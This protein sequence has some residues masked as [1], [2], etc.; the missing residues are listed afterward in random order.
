MDGW[1]RDAIDL[2]GPAIIEITADGCGSLRFVAVEGFIDARHVD[3]DG[4]PAVEFSWDGY[5]EGD[6][7]SGR[8]WARLDEDGSL[9][10]T[11]SSILVTSLAFAWSP[12]TCPNDGLYAL[13]AVVVS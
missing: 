6:Q 10:A 3:L 5:D 8:G 9:R 7:V 2:V 12:L 11:S 4:C 1:D 13:N